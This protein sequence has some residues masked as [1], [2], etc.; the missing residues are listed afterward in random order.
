MSDY[1]MNNPA[2]DAILNTERVIN[3]LK[4]MD[5]Q[6]KDLGGLVSRRTPNVE[7]S[8]EQGIEKIARYVK[9]LRDLRK[10]SKLT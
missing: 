10:Q 6:P 2:F 4:P 3:S 7:E 9:K 1:S 8:R 5:T